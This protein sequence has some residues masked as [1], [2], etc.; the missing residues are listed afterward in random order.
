M[1]LELIEKCFEFIAFNFDYEI[2]HLHY[3]GG[4]KSICTII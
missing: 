3:P 1:I 2:N 4:I